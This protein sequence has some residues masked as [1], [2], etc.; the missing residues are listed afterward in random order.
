MMQLTQ[1]MQ[2]NETAK[3]WDS[4]DRQTTHNR[5]LNDRLGCITFEKIS[6]TIHDYH[7]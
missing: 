5:G 6:S 1:P 2:S 4:G 7:S 3:C